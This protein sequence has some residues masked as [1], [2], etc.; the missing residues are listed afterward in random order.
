VIVV[1]F[2]LGVAAVFADWIADRILGNY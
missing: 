2:L 1:V